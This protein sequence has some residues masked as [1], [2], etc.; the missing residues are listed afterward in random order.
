MVMTGTHDD[1]LR[2]ARKRLTGAGVWDVDGDLV[3]LVDRFLVRRDPAAALAEF[4][5]AV[6]ERCARIPLGHLTGSV[7]FDGLP[8][9]VGSGVFVP[10]SLSVAL[11]AW[12]AATGVLPYGGRILDL[13]SGVGALGLAISRRRTDATVVCVELDDT[14]AAYLRRNVARHAGLTGRVE[15]LDA[16]LLDPGCLSGSPALTSLWPTHRTWRRMCRCYRSGP[17]TSPGRPSTA[18]R[19]G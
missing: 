9:A 6:T 18:A 15:V 10:R 16:D 19:M 12:A 11:V 5:T 4:E 17:I 8:L 3:A 14:A 2:H 13:C 7:T 1:A